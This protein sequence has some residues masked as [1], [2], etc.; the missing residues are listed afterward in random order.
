MEAV[1]GESEVKVRVLI[2]F[3]SGWKVALGK[4]VLWLWVW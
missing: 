1:G 4:V 3:C 2:W